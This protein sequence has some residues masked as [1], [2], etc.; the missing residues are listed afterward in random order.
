MPWGGYGG[1]G[2]RGRA[3]LPRSYT[4][5]GVSY[6]LNTLEMG[7]SSKPELVDNCDHFYMP[8]RGRYRKEL[9]YSVVG[10]GTGLSHVGMRAIRSQCG[11]CRPQ[12]S[13]P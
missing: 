12:E 10:A 4:S 3:T 7:C 13:E 8:P 5:P 6:N 9:S 1:K 2:G 11:F